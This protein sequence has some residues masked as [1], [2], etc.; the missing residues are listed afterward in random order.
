M[1]EQNVEVVR[2]FIGNVD[3]AAVARD[4]EAWAARL[5]ETG[6]RFRP[7]FEFVAHAP[8]GLVEG[9]GLGE[10]RA[11]L[12]DWIEPWETY[13]PRIEELIDLGDRVVVL[14]QDWGRLRGAEAEVEGPKG[15]VIY[16]FDANE[17]VGVEL[18]FDREQGRRA[19]GL[20]GE[21]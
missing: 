17:I 11:Q 9:R 16:S 19:A 13:M 1:S 14:G 5:E 20:D 2:R 10:Y 8:A 21:L 3:L 4:D 6:G 7:G 12:L 18:F 15:L